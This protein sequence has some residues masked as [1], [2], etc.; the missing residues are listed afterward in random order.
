MSI[1]DPFGTADWLSMSEPNS[2]DEFQLVVLSSAGTDRDPIARALRLEGF[3]PTFISDADKV[4]ELLSRT[5]AA[6]LLHDWEAVLPAEGA[7]LHQRLSRFEEHSAVCRIIY[8]Q[9][10][11]PQL[12]ALAADSGVR[13]LISYQTTIMNLVGEIK[14]ALH[15]ARNMNVL[16]AAIHK[17]NAGG[18]Y[19]QGEVDDNVRKAH[20]QFPNDP[21]V[22]LEFGNLC[23]RDGDVEHSHLIAERLLKKQPQNVRAMNLMARVLMKTGRHSEATKFLENA[24]GLSPFNTDRLLMLGE[25]FLSQGE[26]EK[27]SAYYGQA[28][29]VDPEN[30]AARK[31]LGA[32]RLQEGD[33][34]AA[35]DLLRNSASE[36]EAAGLFNNAAVNAAK[37]G[38]DD[39]SLR[40]YQ[41][42]LKV[43]KTDKLKPAVYFN[44]ALALARLG[45]YVEARKAV[46]RALKFDPKH[47][48]AMRLKERLEQLKDWTGEPSPQSKAS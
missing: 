44:V 37:Q 5:R 20:E 38:K 1:S 24:N 11:T 35:L 48:K 36:E 43:L 28:V 9:A 16:Q 15:A 46:K 7:K 19:A 4:V 47:V 30:L 33:I 32:M 27:A 2:L 45:H 10:I 34:N 31:G 3:K 39:E 26:P 22:T 21:V 18:D 12:M 13:R 14:M 40:L 25:A 41:S 8:T 17:V 29:A 23:L 42:A 6:T